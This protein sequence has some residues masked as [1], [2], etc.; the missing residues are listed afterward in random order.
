MS[1]NTFDRAKVA[2]QF[3]P[4]NQRPCCRNCKQA[5]ES[6]A[7]RSP[8]FDTSSWRCMRGGFFVTALA[9]CSQHEPRNQPTKTNPPLITP[10][11]WKP[12]LNG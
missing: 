2:Q 8:T 6:I 1:L 5:K 11:A 10:G 4:A 12:P 9:T 7:D 3:V